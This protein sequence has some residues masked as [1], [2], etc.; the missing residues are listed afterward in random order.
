[1]LAR[2]VWL[3]WAE[4]PD[5]IDALRAATGVTDRGTTVIDGETLHD[6]SI[7]P[8]TSLPIAVPAAGG[9]VEGLATALSALVR[10]DGTPVSVRANA[11]WRQPVGN[12]TVDA[13]RSAEFG[14]EDVGSTVAVEVPDDRGPST[15]RSAS[16]TGCASGRLDGE[17]RQPQVRGRLLRLRRQAARSRRG[18]RTTG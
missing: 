14:F 2:G 17:A 8:V 16:P 1:M 10:A 9:G 13:A 12:R 5:I 3:E 11:T 4:E 15:P 6:L 18:R 7:R